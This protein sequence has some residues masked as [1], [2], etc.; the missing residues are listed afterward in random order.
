MIWGKRRTWQLFGGGGG[1]GSHLLS[2]FPAV[3]NTGV[4]TLRRS[5]TP[6][7]EH[8]FQSSQNISTDA[9][10]DTHEVIHAW[11][12]KWKTGDTWFRHLLKL[13]VAHGGMTWKWD[14]HGFAVPLAELCNSLVWASLQG[15]WPRIKQKNLLDWTRALFGRNSPDCVKDAGPYTTA[16][17]FGRAKFSIGHR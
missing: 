8:G 9:W 12:W 14:R 5:M 15:G 4:V 7:D 6:F 1:R 13:A 16:T 3:L 17:V 11:H 10:W 2:V